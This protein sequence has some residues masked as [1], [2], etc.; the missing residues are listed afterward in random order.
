MTLQYSTVL[1][2][3]LHNTP[4][5]STLVA[6]VGGGNASTSGTTTETPSVTW[7]SQDGVVAETPVTSAGVEGSGIDE[8]HS[9]VGAAA[10]AHAAALGDAAALDDVAPSLEAAALDD[11]AALDCADA[12]ALATPLEAAAPDAAPG[13]VAAH[14]KGLLG[15]KS[16]G[17][18]GRGGREM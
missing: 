8:G 17:L 10:S 6:A 7:I 14:E 4:V 11:A 12:L 18:V 1:Y 13:A 16:A 15:S 9:S 2:R 3:T 5:S